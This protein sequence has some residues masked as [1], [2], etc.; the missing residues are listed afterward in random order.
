MNSLFGY[1]LMW[2]EVDAQGVTVDGGVI[3]AGAVIVGAAVVLAL[4]LRR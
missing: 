3:P 2:R 4:L 1:Q